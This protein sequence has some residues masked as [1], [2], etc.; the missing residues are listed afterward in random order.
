MP[1]LD[2]PSLEYPVERITFKKARILGINTDFDVAKI[3]ILENGQPTGQVYNNVPLFY[4]C[5]PDANRLENGALEGAHKAFLIDDVV[6]VRLEDG[7][8]TVVAIDGKIRQCGDPKILAKNPEDGNWYYI[9]LPDLSV[10]LTTPLDGEENLPNDF[11]DNFFLLGNKHKGN[12]SI[13]YISNNYGDIVLLLRRKK[14]IPLVYYWQGQEEV[15]YWGWGDCT[16]IEEEKKAIFAGWWGFDILDISGDR[17]VYQETIPWPLNY[18]NLLAWEIEGYTVYALR[19]S[20]KTYEEIRVD[21]R[22]GEI[23]VLRT[24]DTGTVDPAGLPLYDCQFNYLT[25]RFF[26]LLQSY[27]TRTVGYWDAIIPPSVYSCSF[28]GYHVEGTPYENWYCD[29]QAGHYCG[30]WRRDYSLMYVVDEQ[31]TISLWE[32]IPSVNGEYLSY[33]TLSVSDGAIPG[34]V[35]IAPCSPLPY[36]EETFYYVCKPGSSVYRSGWVVMPDGQINYNL[37]EEVN[38]C[39]KTAPPKYPGEPCEHCV[40]SHSVSTV[41]GQV[42]Y[43]AG[44]YMLGWSQTSSSY[45]MYQLGEQDTTP[46]KI[47]PLNQELP[48]ITPVKFFVF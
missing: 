32:E 10:Q 35:W 16:V 47:W 31:G 17:A 20:W 26:I 19:H 5:Q 4:H 15:Y 30:E 41:I 14:I 34:P 8:P 36:N 44:C 27:E 7:N 48:I 1:R 24:I 40:A 22:T 29:W 33:I 37:I 13:V 6:I 23:R 3:E 28:Y 25:K 45:A 18:D 12:Y 21:I 2:A 11:W 9:N 43:Y 42:G 39:D 46:A 38:V